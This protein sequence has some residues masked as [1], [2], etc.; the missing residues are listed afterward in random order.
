MKMCQRR[1]AARRM[2]RR[3]GFCR[4]G[5]LA[6]TVSRQHRIDILVPKWLHPL[7]EMQRHQISHD[8]VTIELSRGQRLHFLLRNIDAFRANPGDKLRYPVFLTLSNCPVKGLKCRMFPLKPQR[9]DMEFAPLEVYRQLDA[10]NKLG[11]F[12][13]R[14]KGA[15]FASHQL[16]RALRLVKAGNIVVIRQGKRPDAPLPRQLRQRRRRIGSVGNR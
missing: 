3:E 2:D 4:R 5:V 8:C 15:T 10:G 14:R 16:C 13:A 6:A 9:Y 7:G 11:P 12:S 1:D